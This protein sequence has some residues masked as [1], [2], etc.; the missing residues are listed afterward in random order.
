MMLAQRLLKA[1][2]SVLLLTIAVSPR[3]SGATTGVTPKVASPPAHVRRAAPV[4][5]SQ[6]RLEVD[7]YL[8]EGIQRWG[9]NE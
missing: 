3:M 2:A 9:L 1:P 4:V 7:D 5:K 6:M 8:L